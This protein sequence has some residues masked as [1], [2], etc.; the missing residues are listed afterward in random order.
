MKIYDSTISLLF[1]PPRSSSDIRLFHII[2]YCFALNFWHP[3]KTNRCML[4]VWMRV[5]VCVMK[6][7]VL[8]LFV[9]VLCVCVLCA[10]LKRFFVSIGD[11]LDPATKSENISCNFILI[12]TW[13]NH[14]GI[15]DEK[16]YAHFFFS[17][18]RISLYELYIMSINNSLIV[19]Y[20]WAHFTHIYVYVCV[21]VC[22]RWKMKIFFH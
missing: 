19:W 12:V 10:I 14:K 11:R 2:L 15:D 7:E 9:Q 4:C 20:V 18:H 21:C 16:V 13:K 5:Q 1:R 6:N 22:I 3:P 17:R 8:L